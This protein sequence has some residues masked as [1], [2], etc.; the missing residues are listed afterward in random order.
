MRPIGKDLWQ[1]DGPAIR[2]PGGVRMPLASAVLRL[3]D[4]TLLLYSPIRLDDAHAAAIAAHGDVAHIVAPNLLHHL[5]VKSASER[6]P[7]AIVHGAPGLA[8]KRGDLRFDREL[9]SGTLDANLDVEVI[10]GAPKAN[11]V[12]LFHRPSGALVCADFVFNVTKPANLR[13]RFALALMGVGG[14][15]L[16]QS[17]LW[18]VLAKD[19]T[20]VRASIDR[21]LGWPIT[22][23]LPVHGEAAVIDSVA[24][25]PK[26]ARAYGR[27]P[28][29]LLTS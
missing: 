14:G 25:A 24:L 26:L 10:R 1:L 16:G 29:A 7:R 17:R 22:T 4:G 28:K 27:R 5:H 2:M 8:Q 15:E 19:R 6:W 9:A 3:A 12:V 20:A 13:T 18:R 23:V 11:E 21:V